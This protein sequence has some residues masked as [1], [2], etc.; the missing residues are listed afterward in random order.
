M[1][2]Y[3]CALFAKH[4]YQ[5]VSLTSK[6]WIFHLLCI[7]T[8][9]DFVPL[10]APNLTTAVFAD[11][12]PNGCTQRVSGLLNQTQPVK[13][14]LQYFFRPTAHASCENVL[15]NE[16]TLYTRVS[17]GQK[18][19]VFE[20]DLTDSR[21]DTRQT[22]YLTSRFMMDGVASPCSRPVPLQITGSVHTVISI[23]FAHIGLL[24]LIEW[25]MLIEL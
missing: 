9:F 3:V 14:M 19:I 23:A 1:Y 7:H 10:A 20:V 12:S 5:T 6:I 22:V 16:S 17:A 2:A 4:D 8:L 11:M 18:E 24:W 15:F 21:L 13:M 25:M